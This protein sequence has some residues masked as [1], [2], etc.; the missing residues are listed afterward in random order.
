MHHH[1]RCLALWFIVCHYLLIASADYV[2]YYSWCH[3]ALSSLNNIKYELIL[4]FN[5]INDKIIFFL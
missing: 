2:I 5:N 3:W 4:I 1:V